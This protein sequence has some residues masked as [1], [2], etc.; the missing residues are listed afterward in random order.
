MYVCVWTFSCVVVEG[1]HEACENRQR[2][3][4]VWMWR[5]LCRLCEQA[6]GCAFIPILCDNLI[7]RMKVVQM[8]TRVHACHVAS[9]TARMGRR[10][11]ELRQAVHILATKCIARQ[12]SCASWVPEAGSVKPIPPIQENTHTSTHKIAA[13]WAAIE[14][15]LSLYALVKSQRSYGTSYIYSGKIVIGISIAFKATL[16]GTIRPQPHIWQIASDYTQIGMPSA[17][18]C[19]IQLG[20][21]AILE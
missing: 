7:G 15:S 9:C 2:T 11:M 19:V 8:T 16:A 14:A 5:R 3:C 4:N 6:Y 18:G 1:M 17:P 20:F 10:A 12:L 13:H 21:S